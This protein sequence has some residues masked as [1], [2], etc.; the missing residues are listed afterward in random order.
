MQPDQALTISTLSQRLFHRMNSTLKRLLHYGLFAIVI[1]GALALSTDSLARSLQSARR[2]FKSQEYD[3][4]IQQ[5][6]KHLRKNK[7]DYAA[8]N[9]L[10]ASYYHAGLPKRAL[11]YLRRVAK[12]TR[13]ISYNKYYQGLCLI[14]IGSQDG[15]KRTL[16]SAARYR[17]EY[18]SRAAFEL[19]AMAYNER[20][21]IEAHGLSSRGFLL[22]PSPS[23]LPPRAFDRFLQIIPLQ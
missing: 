1:T 17:D 14:A 4:A 19:G 16:Q 6:R 2:A 7:S 23:R 21:A 15:A 18:G 20:N 9:E 11:R 12:R 22:A 8:W 5:Y 3:A 13:S 10:A